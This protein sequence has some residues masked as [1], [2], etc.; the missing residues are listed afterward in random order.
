MTTMDRFEDCL[1][2][3]AVG[4]AL[5]AVIEFATWRQIQQRHGPDG[6]RELP[7]PAEFTDD[8]QMTLFTAEGLIRTSTRLRA[9]GI[10]THVDVGR[11]ALLLWYETPAGGPAPFSDGW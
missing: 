1:V 11:Y 9:K 10:T 6:L 2:A 5:G 7:S 8:T 4:D 3:G